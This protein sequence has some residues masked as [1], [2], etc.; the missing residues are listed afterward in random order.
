[1]N[2]QNKI[3]VNKL[4][5]FSIFIFFKFFSSYAQTPFSQIEELSNQNFNMYP[6]TNE[7]VT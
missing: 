5:Y 3:F 7:M 6:D 1:M 2:I 4:L